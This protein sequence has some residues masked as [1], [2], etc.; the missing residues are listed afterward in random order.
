VVCPALLFYLLKEHVNMRKATFWNCSSEWILPVSMCQFRW[1]Q[2]KHDQ[3]ICIEHR[4]SR[5][6]DLP[7]TLSL[8]NFQREMSDPHQYQ[9]QFWLNWQELNR[10]IPAKLDLRQRVWYSL[11]FS[12]TVED[13]IYQEK[14]SMHN[15]E[16]KRSRLF[17]R[18]SNTSWEIIQVL[19]CQI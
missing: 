1:H 12:G 16:V 15:D 18:E 7:L 2:R 19:Q 5:V 8:N 4:R 9:W 14:L 6:P 17:S 13:K 10:I 11:F 3:R